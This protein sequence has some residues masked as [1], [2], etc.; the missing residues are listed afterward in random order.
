MD[1][2]KW[3]PEILHE[4]EYLVFHNYFV[5]FEKKKCFSSEIH[6]F[7]SNQFSLLMY[8]CLLPSSATVKMDY[9]EYMENAHINPRRP[10]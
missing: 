10:Y 7:R 4:I 5:F 3:R 2:S 6:V 9:E 1:F 8:R